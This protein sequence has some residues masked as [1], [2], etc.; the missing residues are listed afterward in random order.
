[1]KKNAKFIIVFIISTIIILL[2]T[3]YEAKLIKPI[4][5]QLIFLTIIITLIVAL[6]SFSIYKEKNF[7]EDKAFKFVIPL[8]CIMF[9]VAMPMFR[10]HDEDTHW[11]RIYDIANGNL[12]VPTEY[13]E[14]FQEGAT[15]YP[16]TEIPKAVFDI[17]DRE[18]T[19]G[20]NFKELYEYTINEDETI[21]VA[22]PTEALYSPIQYIPQVTGTLIAKMFTNRPIVMAYMARLFNMI[23]TIIILYFAMK[24][25]PFGKKIFLAVM[26]IPIA[27]EGFTSLSSDAMTISIAMLLIAYIFNII[28]NKDKKIVTWKDKVILGTLCVII[29]LCKIVY[30]PL[31]GLLLL[32]PK[33]KFSSKTNKIVTVIIIIAIATIIN[34]A[35]LYIS[36]QY[37]AEYKEGRPVEQVQKLLTNPIEY[38]QTVFHSINLNGNK[39]LMSMF[40]G[41][42]GLNE[43]VILNTVIPYTFMFLCLILGII[44]NDIKNKLSKFQNCIIILIILA[45]TALIFTSLYIQW[46]PTESTSIAGIQG[47][48]FLPILPLAILLMGNLKIKANYKEETIVKFMS[49]TILLTQINVILSIL[50]RNI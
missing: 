27:V 12:F 19:A 13:G 23:T 5:W 14:I 17:V 36:S 16:A 11:L 44:D 35:W 43:H 39:Y 10:N 41:E 20:H 3:L 34:L 28:F 29:A 21:I 47:R 25:I 22:L 15:N 8:I 37:L 48:Y 1:M 6:M 4:S 24:L 50:S 32:L 40:G 45:I 33:E 31:V 30:L 49:I 9:F 2:F 46:T 18:K 38:L 26:A 42:L 7:T